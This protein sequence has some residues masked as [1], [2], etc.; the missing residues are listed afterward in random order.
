MAFQA[1]ENDKHMGMP[2]GCGAWG[3][4]GEE[5]YSMS[6]GSIGENCG[7][8]GSWCFASDASGYCPYI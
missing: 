1:P 6:C 3:Y 2:G 8:S 7:Q 5:C 4:W